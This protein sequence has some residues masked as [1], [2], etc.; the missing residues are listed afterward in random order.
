MTPGAFRSPPR[1]PVMR[2]VISYV[3]EDKGCTAGDKQE[4][5]ASCLPG[6]S[7]APTPARRGGA[8]G[9]E[10]GAPVD[11]GA[12]SPLVLALAALLARWRRA[13]SIRI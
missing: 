9:C 5:I 11:L 3:N 10:L 8:F 4:I 12:L 6:S 1:G 7:G 2:E 13:R